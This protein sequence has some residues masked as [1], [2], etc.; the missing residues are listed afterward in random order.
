MSNDNRDVEMLDEYDFSEARQGPAIPP[1]RGK[2]RITIRIDNDILDWFRKRVHEQGGGN[3]Q[4]LINETLRAFI[5]NPSHVDAV[6]KL[7]LIEA[8]AIS[9]LREQKL[10]HHLNNR[11]AEF[12][13]LFQERKDTKQEEDP[14]PSDPLW[15]SHGK[16][17][18]RK[19]IR[20]V[21]QEELERTR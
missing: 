19:L 18:L 1:E 9:D 8:C 6:S 21:V 12:A 15:F 5:Q 17:T 14:G 7:A 16:E 11:L 2:T 4:T 20:E 10:L 13:A 3:Y